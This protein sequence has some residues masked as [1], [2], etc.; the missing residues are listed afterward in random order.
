LLH[1]R[2]EFGLPMIT[3]LPPMVPMVHTI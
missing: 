1:A 3:A 2:P